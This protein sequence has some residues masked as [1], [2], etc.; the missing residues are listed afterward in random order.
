MFKQNK[1]V[2]A[3]FETGTGHKLK[4]AAQAMRKEVFGEEVFWSQGPFL[5]D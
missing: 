2:H 3:E 1:G 4:S 5:C